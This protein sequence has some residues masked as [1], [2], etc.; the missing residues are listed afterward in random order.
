MHETELDALVSRPV[1]SRYAPFRTVPY[2]SVPLWEGLGG[3]E[4]H[5]TELEA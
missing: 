3:S 1:P 4:M 2:L 5:E